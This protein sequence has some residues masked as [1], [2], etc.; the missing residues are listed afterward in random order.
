M[1][2]CLA[3][4][5]KVS[6]KL[7]L[8]LDSHTWGNPATSAPRVLE[9]QVGVSR[10]SFSTF[11]ID[12]YLCVRA[13]VRA[14]VRTWMYTTC[15]HVLPRPREDSRIPGAGFSGSCELFDVFWDSNSSPLT[16]LWKSK[17]PSWSLSHLSSPILSY[18]QCI[19]LYVY[20]I[21]FWCFIN[22]KIF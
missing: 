19:V 17:K 6:Q 10:P 15:V 5:G 11:K 22:R 16:V 1:S 2:D 7:W 12:F 9:L 18:F 3:F 8:A 21:K 4:S 14:C 20:V 13:C